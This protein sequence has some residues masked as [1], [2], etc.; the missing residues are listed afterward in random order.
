LKTLRNLID[1][2]AILHLKKEPCRCRL[3]MVPSPVMQQRR[4]GK[5]SNTET[6]WGLNRAG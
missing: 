5:L 6:A 1:K 3:Q 4:Y 2:G